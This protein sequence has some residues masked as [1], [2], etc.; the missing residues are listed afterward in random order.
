[1]IAFVLGLLTH[2]G[3]SMALVGFAPMKLPFGR[4]LMV[5]VGASFV[6]L[7]APAGIGPA[8]LYLRFLNRRGVRTSLAVATVALVQVAGFVVTVLLLIV[9]S[10]ATGKPG[11]LGQLRDRAPLAGAAA[12]AAAV[13][14][15]M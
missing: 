9:F 10:L 13:T 5:E 1:M 12:V 14:V 4:V 11:A 2:V 6:K 15:L 8:A 3:A 7:V